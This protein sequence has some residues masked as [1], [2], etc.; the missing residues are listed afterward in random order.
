MVEIL[1]QSV[2]S[3][4]NDVR[5]MIRLARILWPIYVMPLNGLG[6][7]LLKQCCSSNGGGNENILNGKV[8]VELGEKARFHIK[9]LLNECLLQPYKSLRDVTPG[10]DK[11]ATVEKNGS[12][13]AGSLS[14]R[15]KFLLLAAFLCQS[16]KADHDRKLY[17]NQASGRRKRRRKNQQNENAAENI[18][19]AS[20][21]KAQQLLRSE[22][23]PSFPLERLLSI[24]SSIS[25]KYSTGMKHFVNNVDELGSIGLIAN[26]NELRQLGYLTRTSS[27]TN[28]VLDKNRIVATKYIC[29]LSQN[30]AIQL[31]KDVKFPLANYLSENI[32]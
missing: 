31:A 17:T 32:Q 3:T 14:Y 19:H 27:S 9:R 24:F 12:T 25:A 5:E 4:T 11:Q 16:N 20:S 26:L 21:A 1:V 10:K 28:S 13:L 18:T 30:E 7:Q 15:T 22:K 23:V 29:N 6:N 8:S 2:E